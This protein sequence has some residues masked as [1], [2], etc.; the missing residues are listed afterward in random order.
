MRT[1]DRN[2]PVRFSRSVSGERGGAA[3]FSALLLAAGSALGWLED[4]LE[5][6]R[7]RLS[8]EDLTE[9]AAEGYRHLARRCL[10]RGVPVL[11]GL[12]PIRCSR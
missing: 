2:S 12:G 10:P 6:R 5:K 3:S 1:I 9:F 7:S 8:L 11:L 4:R